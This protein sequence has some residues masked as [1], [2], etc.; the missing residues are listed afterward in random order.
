LAN[1]GALLVRRGGSEV[2]VEASSI[3][4]VAVIIVR[5]VL[6]RRELLVEPAGTIRRTVGSR[7][8][9]GVL[10]VGTEAGKS[11]I[12]VNF[13]T[14]TRFASSASE[15]VSA[16]CILAL[17]AH[18]AFSSRHLLKRGGF[19]GECSWNFHASRWYSKVGEVVFALLSLGV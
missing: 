15:G 18:A 2:V 12:K 11:S 4:A 17:V 16:V 19:P 3:V 13:A 7:P 9:A 8:R 14:R 10:A 1:A 5:E 6:N